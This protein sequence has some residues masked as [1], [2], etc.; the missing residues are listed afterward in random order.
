LPLPAF[1]AKVRAS[2]EGNSISKMSQRAAHP[3]SYF[4]HPLLRARDWQDRPEFD[5]LCDWWR[6]YSLSSPT[7]QQTTV[8][9]RDSLSSSAEERA[10]VRSRSQPPQ[11]Q[12]SAQPSFHSATGVCALVGIGGAGKT[13]IGERF[14]RVLPS[15]L[16]ALP[17]V[18]KD[19][20]L[21]PP[22]SLFVF[23]FYDAPNPDS[24]F[25]QLYAWLSG[26]PFDE[27][28]KTPS[29]QQSLQL[30]SK[31]AQTFLSAGSSNF[32]VASPASTGWES[33]SNPPSSILH[34]PS[35]LLLI[36]DGLEK[37]Q[38]DGARGGT[39]G[40]ILD[41]RL[42]DLILRAADGWLPGVALLITSRFR[43]FE[44]EMKRSSFFHSI[45]I[46]QLQPTAA[47]ALLRARSVRAPNAQ[48]VALCEESGYHALTLD[49]MSGYVAAFCDG[50]PSLLPPLAEAKV[51]DEAAAED[52]RLAAVKEQERKF[53]RLAQRCG[54][55]MI[56]RYKRVVS[57]IWGAGDRRL[58]LR[59]QKLQ[60][61]N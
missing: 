53:G 59:N 52:P 10:G 15:G 9:H 41:G 58:G 47:L 1:L 18:A 2:E 43:L 55:A 5:A 46:D 8:I 25:S 11:P 61:P 20:T 21:P 39:F 33:P 54:E 50:D 32:P 34:S 51:P 49:L 57:L 28:A 13:A 14:L 42:R 24:F 17:N 4:V 37:V 27:S 26:T 12:L 22:R 36:L 48:L 40:Q 45:N 56:C 19:E 16:P 7:G 44:A 29:Y 60:C 6:G 23:S 35:S 31:V 38:D 30:L 3:S